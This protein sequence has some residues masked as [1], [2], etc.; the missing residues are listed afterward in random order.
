MTISVSESRGTWIA[1]GVGIW[2]RGLIFPI[3]GIVLFAFLTTEQRQLVRRNSVEPLAES[4][5]AIRP[6]VNPF[7][8]G[9]DSVRTISIHHYTRL[10]DPAGFIAVTDEEFIELLGELGEREE[11]LFVNT[12]HF[13]LGRAFLPRSFALLGNREVFAEP[14]V[15]WGMQQPCTRFVYRYKP[16]GLTRVGL[17]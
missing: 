7:S 13:G 5:A 12:A 16:G 11:P 14:E 15:F 3:V 17:E 8:P 10:Y 1:N 9:I 2:Y 4:I 6:V